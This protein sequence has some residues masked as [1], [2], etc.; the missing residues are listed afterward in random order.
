MSAGEQTGESVEEAIA[1]VMGALYPSASSAGPATPM[2]AEGVKVVASFEPQPEHRGNSGWL[3]GGLAATVLDHVCARAAS[4]ALGQRVVTGTLDLRYP[5][6]VPLAGGPYRVEAEAAEP[7]RR[8]VR[9]RGAI[10][11]AQGRPMVEAKALFVV[12]PAEFV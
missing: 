3:Q 12:R 6:P 5:R 10:L 1:R 4:A 2:A 9:V 11:D 8:M 7:R